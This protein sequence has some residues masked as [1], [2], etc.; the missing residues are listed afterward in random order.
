MRS[1]ADFFNLGGKFCG[2]GNA[3]HCS[4]P[5]QWLQVGQEGGKILTLIFLF[6]SKI[7]MQ[8]FLP[9]GSQWSLPTHPKIADLDWEMSRNV[10]GCSFQIPLLPARLWGLAPRAE[11]NFQDFV[12]PKVVAPVLALVAVAVAVQS[13]KISGTLSWG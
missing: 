12:V 9:A 2:D 3:Q 1:H 6:A 10:L 13:Q 4:D 7:L 5:A 8:V 11:Q